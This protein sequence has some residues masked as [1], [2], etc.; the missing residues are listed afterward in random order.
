MLSFNWEL[1]LYDLL[2]VV[3]SELSCVWSLKNIEQRVRHKSFPWKWKKHRDEQ[4]AL[5]MRQFI[6]PTQT[7]SLLHS[8]LHLNQHCSV[9]NHHHQF[10][11]C[12]GACPHLVC[13]VCVSHPGH[14]WHVCTRVGPWLD[15]DDPKHSSHS[16]Y[17]ALLI[18]SGKNRCDKGQVSP[19]ASWKSST[20]SGSEMRLVSD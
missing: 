2:Q 10:L 9:G 1:N 11:K 12:Y 8:I 6:K 7:I 17:E 16:D 15:I 18:I 13:L 5:Q 19:F 14:L 4:H 3:L 20:C